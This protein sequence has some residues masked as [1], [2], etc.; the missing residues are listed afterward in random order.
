MKI[1]Q[2]VFKRRFRKHIL[3]LTNKGNLVELN[4]QG[5]NKFTFIFSKELGNMEYKFL[6]DTIDKIKSNKEIDNLLKAFK[7]DYSF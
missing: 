3:T 6:T 5:K 1:K 4:Y 7:T 2:A